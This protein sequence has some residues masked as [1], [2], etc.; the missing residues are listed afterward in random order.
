MAEA[1]TQYSKGAIFLHWLIAI[2][3]IGQLAGGLY[4]VGIPKEQAA[5]KLEIFQL[6]K[7]FG[8]TILLLTIVRLMW[9]LGHRAPALPASMP[10][11]EMAAARGSHF[12]FYLLLIGIPLLG[13]AYVSVAPLNVPT[14]LF[15]IVQWP[16]MP[17]FEGVTDR[18]EVAEIFEESH[19]VAAKAAIGLLILHVAAAL[20]HHFISGDDVL[21]RMLPLVRTRR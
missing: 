4:M 20:K 8:I 14:M 9:R 17:F 1:Q 11:W 13:W 2:L 21:S 3:V 12:L 6:H 15:G 7:S 5:L 16:H 19:E 18:K 10:G